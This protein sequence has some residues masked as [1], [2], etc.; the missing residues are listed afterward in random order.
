MLFLLRAE[1]KQ[2][3]DMPIRKFYEI[4]DREA[5]HALGA[6]RAGAIKALYKVA[7]RRIVIAIVDVPSHDALDQAIAG[8][9]MTQEMGWGLE[10]VEIL[11]LRPYENFAQ[12]LRQGSS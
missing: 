10:M 8:L 11:P 12:D 4:W 2:P 3:T 1:V 9:P 5:Q 6:V 7:G